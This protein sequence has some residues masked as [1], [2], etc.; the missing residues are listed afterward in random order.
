MLHTL[1]M[2]MLASGGARLR[3]PSGPDRP[4]K[5]LGRVHE[6]RPKS[7]SRGDFGVHLSPSSSMG[8]PEGTGEDPLI[9]SSAMR[10]P[11]RP[12]RGGGSP[13]GSQNHSR[14]MAPVALHPLPG[15]RAG[16]W[17][18]RGS[19]TGLGRA[20]KASSGMS[21]RCFL[22]RAASGRLSWLGAGA[23]A[24]STNSVP[25]LLSFRMF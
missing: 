16:S 3:S 22:S 1:L 23:A 7:G 8:G 19:A 9:P 6:R 12:S 13:W 21:A 10:A 25:S 24:V 18:V 5:S 4:P 11:S 17:G 2:S 14:V 15:V 20:P